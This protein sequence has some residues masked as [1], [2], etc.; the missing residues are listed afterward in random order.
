LSSVTPGYDRYYRTTSPLPIGSSIRCFHPHLIAADRIGNGLEL[1]SKKRLLEK[2]GALLASADPNLS[3]EEVFWRLCERE[4][5]GSTGLGHGVALP[6]ARMQEVTEA[7]GAFVRLRKGVAFDT[8]EMDRSIWPSRCWYPSRSPSCICSCSRSWH[9]C[10]RIH[11][12]A[13]ICTRPP[14]RSRS[15]PS[16]KTRNRIPGIND[17]NLIPPKT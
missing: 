16:W 1:S 11:G 10:S 12:Y 5:L 7:V 6:H 2:L 15:L 14:R 8:L 3:S 17:P 13:G 9:P 4:R